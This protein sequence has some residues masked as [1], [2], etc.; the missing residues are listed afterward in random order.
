M[1]K[2]NPRGGQA[3][4]INAVRHGRYA[5]NRGALDRR[6]DRRSTHYKRIQLRAKELKKALGSEISPQKAWIVEDIARTETLLDGVDVY[7]S[8]LASPISKGRPRP[9]LDIRLRLAA[10]IK[11]SL[12][13]L[14]LGLDKVKKTRSPWG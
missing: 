14:G 1:D 7:L 4:N 6:L 13:K 10:H 2:T 8:Q 3:G 12:A 11:D 9:A 5:R